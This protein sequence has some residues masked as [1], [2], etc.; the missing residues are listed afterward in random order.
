MKNI[1]KKANKSNTIQPAAPRFEFWN[2]DTNRTT[3]NATTALIWT[4]QGFYVVPRMI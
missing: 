2:R 3:T 4:K 1:F